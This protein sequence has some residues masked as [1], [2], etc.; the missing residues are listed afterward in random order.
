MQSDKPL[1]VLAFPPKA[2]AGI[3]F[4]GFSN[5]PISDSQAGVLSVRYRLIFRFTSTGTGGGIEFNI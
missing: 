2:D 5:R 4:P 3:C 1:S